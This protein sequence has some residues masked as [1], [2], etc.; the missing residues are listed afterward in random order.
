MSEGQEVRGVR[1]SQLEA[2]GQSVLAV[3]EPPLPGVSRDR[4]NGS[5][6]ETKDRARRLLLF[7]LS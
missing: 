4:E 7:S 3:T 2:P 6:T 5:V 1:V